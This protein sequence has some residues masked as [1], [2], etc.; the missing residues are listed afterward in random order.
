MYIRDFS[1]QS[2]LPYST[3]I[4]C[5]Y[6]CGWPIFVHLGKDFTYR[7]PSFGI[8]P[9]HHP[10]CNTAPKH[11]ANFQAFVSKCLPVQIVIISFA[12]LSHSLYLLSLEM[13]GREE[14][15]VLPHPICL[16]SGV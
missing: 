2:I 5:I 8:P 9:Y 13:M 3:A 4:K 10:S 14:A 16:A 7:V 6:C 12:S 1:S 11:A 15:V